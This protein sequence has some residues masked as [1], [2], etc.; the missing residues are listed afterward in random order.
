MI[1]Y[2]YDELNKEEK[3]EYDQNYIN[4]VHN[5]LTNSQQNSKTKN[6]EISISDICK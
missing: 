1:L 2:Y 6:R 4:Y 5:F 3:K